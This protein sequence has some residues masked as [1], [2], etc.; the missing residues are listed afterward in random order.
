MPRR[1]FVASGPTEGAGVTA[2]T[3]GIPTAIV[4]TRVS[5]DDQARDGVSLDA[6]LAACRRYAAERHWCLGPEFQDV[7]SGRR[8]DRPAYQALLTEVRRM[9]STGLPV[10]VVVMRL[11]RLGRRVLERSRCREELKELGV[12]STACGRVA[13]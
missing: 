13:R 4:Y 8:D 12:L 3:K 5:K 9:R 11:D 6:Q 10:I 2:V 1:L 7:L